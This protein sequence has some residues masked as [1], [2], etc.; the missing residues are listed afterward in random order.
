VAGE[1]GYFIFRGTTAGE[2]ARLAPYDST[3]ST[4]WQDTNLTPGT[5][6][7]YIVMPYAAAVYYGFSPEASATATG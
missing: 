1:E 6:Y 7:F 3:P 2:A 5:T 4:S